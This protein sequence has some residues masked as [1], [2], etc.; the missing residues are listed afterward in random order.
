MFS[1]KRRAPWALIDDMKMADISHSPRPAEDDIGTRRVFSAFDVLLDRMPG[2]IFHTLGA[3]TAFAAMW[4]TLAF[5]GGLPNGMV[6][7][8]A[9]AMVGAFAYCVGFM[10]PLVVTY[11]VETRSRL[12]MVAVVVGGSAVF[13]AM[14]LTLPI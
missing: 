10:V 8:I 4:F 11:L 3:I 7:W 12:F 14:T 5:L 2:W 6:E 1:N 13:G 9:L